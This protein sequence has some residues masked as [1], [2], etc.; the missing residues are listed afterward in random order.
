MKSDTLLKYAQLAAL[1]AAGV[2]LYR[3]ASRASEAA[4]A[5]ASVVASV[6]DSVKETL[7]TDLNPKSDKNLIYSNL[8]D[9]VTEKVGNFLGAIFGPPMPDISDQSNLKKQTENIS[10]AV[11]TSEAQKRKTA[12]EF[13]LRTIA[14]NET[15]SLLRRY[16]APVLEFDYQ[17]GDFK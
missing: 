5:G 9:S 16:P 11:T 12:S 14:E 6:V 4:S 2:V 3:V 7:K 10:S 1:V 15:A 17:T 13:S 8:P